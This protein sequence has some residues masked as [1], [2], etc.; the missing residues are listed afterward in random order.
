M[1]T[2]DKILGIVRAMGD[3]LRPPERM[4]VSQCA[5][6]YRWLSPEA[7]I[8][9]K[10]QTWPFQREPMDACGSDDP[11]DHVVICAASQLLK[12]E[13]IL[14][15]ITR[16]VICDPGPIAIFE[17][18]GRDADTLSKDRITPMIRD[19]AALREKISEAKSRDSSNT[20]EQ[21]AFPG[22]TLYILGAGSASNL[23]QRPIRYL[24]RDECDRWLK[25]VDNEGSP[26][27]LSERRTTRFWN[28]KIVD[29]S[30]PT[31]AKGFISEQF[32]LSDQRYWHVPCPGCGG[33]QKFAWGGVTWGQPAEGA[34]WEVIGGGRPER[35]AIEDAHYLCAHCNKLIPHSC[36]GQ[37][38]EA[39]RYIAANP[40]SKTK[41]FHA[42]AL[43]YPIRSWGHYA[44]EFE[45]KKNSATE[46]RSF[47]NT[48]LAEVYDEP[49]EKP[50]WEILRARTKPYELCS[51][52]DAVLPEGVLFLTAG[53]DV[54]RGRG[55]GGGWAEAYVWGWGRNK[56]SW[57]INHERINGQISDAD[58]QARLSKFLFEDTYRTASGLTVQI[59]KAAID[60]GEAS[61]VVYE[62]A[63]RQPHGRV[64]V[65]KGSDNGD[66]LLGIPRRVDINRAGKTIKKGISLYM[67]NVSM[68]KREFYAWLLAE[69][70]GDI[71]AFGAVSLPADVSDDVLQQLTIEEWRVTMNRNGFVN[72]H[73]YLP[74]GAR[75][76]ALDCRN[77]ARAA[78]ADIGMDRY[79]ERDWAARESMMGVSTSTVTVINPVNVVELPPVVEQQEA[80]AVTPQ[81]Q[82]QSQRRAAPWIQRKPG[83]WDR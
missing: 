7:S 41:G 79:R 12:T 24:F 37:M 82:P 20:I 73:W 31:D 69:P 72:G 49:G 22:G 52:P 36:K 50:N 33:V 2:E 55:V 25:N 6:R 28:R 75:N 70:I 47:V 77:Y 61:A 29:T 64:M 76:E 15:A 83:F 62:W 4:T 23:A 74:E 19:C 38:N 5:E 57:L 51:A 39:G 16:A 80:A 26:F 44:Q 54:Q 30:S 78:A 40:G 46:Y 60:S 71:P 13:V 18:G 42:N 9:Q 43:C 81:S 35:I 56:R 66:R 21:K 67:V 34:I 11:C 48:V 17:P 27:A 8:A 32:L 53:I 58:V 14:N 65:V 45:E 3:A 1:T 10:W 59:E 63:R 68:A